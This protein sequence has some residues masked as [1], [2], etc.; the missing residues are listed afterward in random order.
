MNGK[1]RCNSPELRE[2]QLRPAK[3]RKKTLAIRKLQHAK[4]NCN[5]IRA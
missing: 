4:T 5:G 3:A 2:P 1:K